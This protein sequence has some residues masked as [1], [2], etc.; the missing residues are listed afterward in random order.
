ML[1]HSMSQ[2]KRLGL[3]FTCKITLATQNEKPKRFLLILVGYS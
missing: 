3:T 2:K 1:I